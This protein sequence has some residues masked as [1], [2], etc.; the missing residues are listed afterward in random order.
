M[1]LTLV[2]VV[3]IGC[4]VQAPTT[5]PGL[6]APSVAA[7]AHPTLL[8]YC[9][10][11]DVG[12]SVGQPIVDL[13]FTTS[14][15]KTIRLGDYYD[16]D[17]KTPTR[18]LHITVFAQWCGPSLAEVDFILGSNFTG[19][20]A[21]GLSWQSELAPK[22]AFIELLG[23]GVTMGVGATVAELTAFSTAHPNATAALATDNFGAFFD[24]AAIPLNLDIDTRTMRI[25]DASVGF[26]TNLDA[27]ILKLLDPG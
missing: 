25:L 5:D 12:M 23:D 27:S 22:V 11:T 20:N 6:L 2:A 17:G 4:S 18:L 13:A 24:A 16:P 10:P 9:Y 3:V 8:G 14:G 15:D 26:D 1:R 21:G 19:G 7:C